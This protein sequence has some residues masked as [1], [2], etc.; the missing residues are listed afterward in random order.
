MKF[1]SF[2]LQGRSS[3]GVVARDDVADI[4]AVCGKR[5]VDLRALIAAEAYGDAR[6][7]AGHAPRIPLADL[8][9]LPVVPNPEKILCV[10][11]NYEEHRKETGHTQTT[12]PTVFARF[13]NSQTGHLNGVPLPRVSSQLDY[14]GELA[15]IIG[16]RGRYIDTADALSHV[17]GYSCYNDLSVR[18]W[19]HHTHQFTPGKNFPGTG[20]L[21]PWM[22]TPEE[23]EL[24]DSM[25][26]QTRVNGEIVQH[27]RLGQMI[28]GVASL[29]TYCSSF[30]QL[31]PGDVILT[32]TPG[33]VGA[34]RQPPRWLQPGDITEVEIDGIGVLRNTI[35]REASDATR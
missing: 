6:E 17:A 22:V 26:L 33:G 25:C 20:A 32:G 24:R 23:L 35:V 16:R 3:W 14:E 29:I 19:Q 13:A 2:Q 31:E 7:A 8:T 28:F 30:T 21:G 5:F 10:G 1:A 34:K 18:D 27:T 9:W 15:V 4:G 11:L 12:Y